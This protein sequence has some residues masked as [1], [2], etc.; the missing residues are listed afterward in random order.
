MLKIFA[1]FLAPVV[2]TI[3][4]ILYHLFRMILVHQFSLSFSFDGFFFVYIYAFPAYLLIAV[5]VSMVIERIN[6]G[7]RWINYTL[8]G[9][10]GGLIVVFINAVNSSQGFV[11]TMG[12]AI[13][14]MTAG[15]S[16]YIALRILEKIDDRLQNQ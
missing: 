16:F 2:L 9:L 1:A 11:F 13:M 10:L 14:Y 3:Y 6:K 4:F 7:I 8:A 5:P 12:W 15:F